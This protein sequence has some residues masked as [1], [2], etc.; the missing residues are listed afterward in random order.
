M[1]SLF[2]LLQEAAQSW[3]KKTWQAHCKEGDYRP[4]IH[5][6][7]SKILNKIQLF[8]MKNM[9]HHNH[10][11]VISGVQGC[12]DIWKSIIVIHYTNR[13]KNMVI[14][15]V[16]LKLYNTTF[17]HYEKFLLTNKNRRKSDKGSS[18]GR[19]SLWHSARVS[20]CSCLDITQICWTFSLHNSER[21]K[22]V[23]SPGH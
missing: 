14:F 6:H 23:N 20:V 19:R 13:V 15:I 10:I 11:E 9:I 21:R 22:D 5:E 12:F 4:I 3:L 18:K 2:W 1:F 7:R 16:V 17:I 8:N